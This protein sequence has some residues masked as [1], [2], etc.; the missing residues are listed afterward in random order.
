M[1]RSC[2]VYLKGAV[3]GLFN[4]SLPE[5][6]IRIPV[7][8]TALMIHEIAHGY[9][10][11]RLGDPTARN[12]G[13]LT[14]NPLKHLDPIG[15][16]CMLLFGFGWARPV[17]INTRHFKKPRRDMALTALAGPVSN[18]IL[19]FIG[20]LL[21]DISIVIFGALLEVSGFSASL[22]EVWL[23]FLSTW[24]S[25][26]VYLGVFNMLPVPPL[27]GSRIFLTFLPPKYYFGIMRYERYIM[28]GLFAAL[29]I[30]L[31]DGVLVFVAQLL[32]K[33]MAFVVSLIP[34]LGAFFQMVTMF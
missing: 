8:L 12:F 16:I 14:M 18:F 10:A 4:L 22:Q 27:D 1:P 33:A 19:T 6:L 32:I 21:V 24:I 25:L 13:R 30:G 11:F 7:V 28:L 17:P 29:Y 23:T 2:S 3:M 31:L 5:I 15:A 20:I 26:N 9:V 34:G